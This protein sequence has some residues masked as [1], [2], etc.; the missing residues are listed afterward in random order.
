MSSLWSEEALAG[1]AGVVTGAGSGI[2][3]AAARL[4]VAAGA[5]VVVA[6]LDREGGE[7]TVARCQGPGRATFFE[8][9]IADP[10]G[11]QAMVDFALERCGRL[12]F[13]YNNAGITAAGIPL[14]EVSDELWARVIGV[15][16]TGTFNCMRAEIKAM[17]PRG[18]GS[19]VNTASALGLV[20]NAGQ[21]AYI[22]AKHGV[23]G[24]TRAAAMDYSA[25]GIRVNALCPGVIETQMM[26]DLVRADPD[27]GQ[28][29][30]RL[31]P[32]GRLGLPEE[33]ANAMLWLVSDAASFVTGQA[34]AVDGAYTT[35]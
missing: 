17:L 13:A 32:I 19:I 7:E 22:T 18:G 27:L 35:Q 1:R 3:R 6:D 25:Q 11:A 31:H 30:Q 5:E 21:S 12:D 2:G 16:L 4:L 23:V 15:D 8:T 24:L 34:I 28:E 9:D 33:V 14:A 20:A 26:E 29:L 10:D